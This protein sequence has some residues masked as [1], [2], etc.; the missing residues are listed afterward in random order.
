VT[1]S[2]DINTVGEIAT[3]ASN[4]YW[5]SFTSSSA[6]AVWRVAISGGEPVQLA[7]GQINARSVAVDD[8]YVYWATEL[9]IL[10]VSK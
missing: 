1:L 9:A 3:D 8:S 10:R 4:V 5:T 6:G 2:T 7:A